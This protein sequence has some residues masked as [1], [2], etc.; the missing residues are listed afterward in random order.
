MIMAMPLGLGPGSGPSM[1]DVRRASC[2]KLVAAWVVMLSL[3]VPAQSGEGLPVERLHCTGIVTFDDAM[4]RAVKW[5]VDLPS[6]QVMMPSC[7]RYPELLGFCYGEILKARD[8][9]FQ[10]GGAESWENSRMWVMLHRIG[11]AP[12]PEAR[13][14]LFLGRCVPV[15]RGICPPG[16]HDPC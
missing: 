8:H 6:G 16:V 1:R 9:Y 4:T 10:F 12:V 2:R 11:F 13:K 7:G 15:I 14:V 5:A 3:A